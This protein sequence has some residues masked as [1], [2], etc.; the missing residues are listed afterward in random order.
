[1]LRPQTETQ[2]EDV[3]CQVKYVSVS[4]R[5]PHH[6]ASSHVGLEYPIKG[7]LGVSAVA[8]GEHLFD[9][10]HAGQVISCTYY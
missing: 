8:D 9:I 3:W 7:A 10:V 2:A 4:K 6:E 5:V 1:M